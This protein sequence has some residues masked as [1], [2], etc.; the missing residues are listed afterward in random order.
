VEGLIGRAVALVLLGLVSGAAS[1]VVTATGDMQPMPALP[2]PDLSGVGRLSNGCSAVLLRGGTHLLGAAHCHVGPGGYVSFASGAVAQVVHV[3]L[4]PDWAG[5]PGAN[6]LA[7]M[8]LAA[9]PEGIEGYALA[10]ARASNLPCVV[11]IAGWGAGGTGSTGADGAT[12]PTG[13]LRYGYN[14]Y[15]ALLPPIETYGNRVAMFDFDDGTSAHNSMGRTGL[16]EHEAMLAALDSGGPSFVAVMGRWMIAGIHAGIV[17][18][19][20]TA[21]GGIGLDVRVAPYARWIASQTGA[22]P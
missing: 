18:H 9:P 6:D 14:Q 8:T 15:E 17:T 10:P 22:A 20:G 3:A 19:K 12:H 7:V 1:A 2:A 4:A 5:L 21:F 13:T 11:L 16:A